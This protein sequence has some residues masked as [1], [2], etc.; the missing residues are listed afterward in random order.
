MNDKIQIAVNLVA[1]KSAQCMTAVYTEAFHAIRTPPIS[2]PQCRLDLQYPRFSV[3][4]EYKETN[5][6]LLLID[7][8]IG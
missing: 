7:L 5:L 4:P 8:R 1:V 2:L 6:S 3:Q